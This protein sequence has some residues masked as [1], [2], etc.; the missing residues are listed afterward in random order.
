MHRQPWTPCSIGGTRPTCKSPNNRAASPDRDRRQEQPRKICLSYLFAKTPLK[1]N[2]LSSRFNEQ[3][4]KV[5]RWN[6][7]EVFNYQTFSKRV[8]HVRIGK[9]LSVTEEGG[10]IYL[11]LTFSTILRHCKSLRNANV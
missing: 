10:N 1:P 2:F 7:L 6:S 5:H 4:C 11:C 8:L 3:R 9:G